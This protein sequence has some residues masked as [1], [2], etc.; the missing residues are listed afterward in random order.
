MPAPKPPSP[1][2]AEALAQINTRV[3]VD[4]AGLATNPMAD[5]AAQNISNGIEQARAQ[6]LAEAAAANRAAIDPTSPENPPSEC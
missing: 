6:A 3:A 4:I 1:D 5:L 2:A